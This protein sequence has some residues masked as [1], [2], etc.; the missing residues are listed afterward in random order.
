MASVIGALDSPLPS[1]AR[2]LRMRQPTSRPARSPMAKGPMAS[3]K[4]V[5]ARSTSQGIAPSSIRRWACAPYLAS[6]RLPTKPSQ[7]PTTTGSLAVLLAMSIAVLSTSGAGLVAAHDLE[8]AHDIGRREIVHAEH[9]LRAFGDGGDLVDV[10]RRG[11][12]GQDRAGLHD[13]VELGEHLLLDVHFLEHGL[14]DHVAI[15]DVL[16]VEH[17]RDQAEPLVHLLLL[18]TA[19]LDLALPVAG[20]DLA[21]TVVR[22][23]GHLQLHDGNAGVGKRHG[24]AAAHRAGADHGDLLDGARRRLVV[25]AGHLGRLALGEEGVDLGAALRLAHQGEEQLALAWRAPASNGSVAP[26]STAS[27]QRC[28]AS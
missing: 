2:R 23:L 9:V 6:M 5:S 4:L 18:E 28:G 22:F 21:A 24:D 26:A 11:V 3:P 13:G 14:D 20:H 10:E 27:M 19:A 16:V 17:G 1:A 8:Q 12:G 15:G 25:D 7:T